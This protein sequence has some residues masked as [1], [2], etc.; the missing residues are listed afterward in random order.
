[1]VDSGVLNSSGQKVSFPEYF[2][3]ISLGVLPC[4]FSEYIVLIKKKKKN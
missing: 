2:S 4:P 1:M 3:G